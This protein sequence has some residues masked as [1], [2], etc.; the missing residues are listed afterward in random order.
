MGGDPLFC[1][2]KFNKIGVYVNIVEKILTEDVKNLVENEGFEFIELKYV[3]RGKSSILRIFADSD[4]GITIDECKH[5]SDLI[6]DYIFKYNKIEG[7]YVLEVSSPGVDRP[8]KTERDFRKNLG[9]DVTINYRDADEEKQ[10]SGIVAEV[11]DQVVLNF[12]EGSINI[13]L[14]KIIEGKIKLKW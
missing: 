6:S 10:I 12:K 7:D 3:P 11:S 14:D 1:Y 8:L 13:P 9:R 5:L 4:N 2:R